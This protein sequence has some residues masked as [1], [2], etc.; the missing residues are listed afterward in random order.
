MY[1]ILIV[2]GGVAGLTA[3]IYARR[4]G[5]TVLL[6]EG[7]GLGG[8]IAASPLV[9]NYPGVPSI[10][11][12][13]LSDALSAQAKDLGT[14]VKYGQV[15]GVEKTAQGFHL[16]AGK[17]EYEGRAL[18][19]C[20]GAKHRKLGLEKE[21]SFVGRGVSYCATCDGAF[22]RD[23]A[24]AVVGGGDSA[25][26]SALF[27]SQICSSVTLIHR[28]EELRAQ[29][30]YVDAAQAR[31]NIRFLLSA[32]VTALQ[33]EDT[34]TAVTVKENGNEHSLAVEG[35]FIEVGQAPD[36]GPFAALAELD[37]GGYFAA[38]ENCLTKTPG[39]FVAGDCR[40]KALR[41]LTT[42]ASDGS[43]AATA[44]CRW[45]DGQ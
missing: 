19:L 41:Q 24:V 25:L 9:E 14:E 42:A 3:A 4:A 26:Q 34:L 28:R 17:R 6:L 37:E 35:L 33:G 43:V 27:L 44:A 15:T 2:G 11:G 10:S 16:T 40:A 22:F 23:K 36:N 39:V 21:D 32:Q 8:Q 38:G 13:E 7:V 45:L 5:R 1:D 30:A 12:T 18:I 20:T 31:E 29:R